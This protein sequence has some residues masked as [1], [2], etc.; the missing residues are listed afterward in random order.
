MNHIFSWDSK[1]LLILRAFFEDAK[2]SLTKHKKCLLETSYRTSQTS[3]L[4]FLQQ[5]LSAY[6]QKQCSQKVPPYVSE[7][8][9]NSTNS[10]F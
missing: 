3:K 9:L 10:Y 7:R 8:V 2:S 5:K 4:S 1:R 6:S